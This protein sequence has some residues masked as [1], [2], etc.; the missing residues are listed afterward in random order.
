MFGNALATYV[1]NEVAGMRAPLLPSKSRSTFY[2]KLLGRLQSR[3]CDVYHAEFVSAFI[4]YRKW[5]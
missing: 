5:Y 4:D 2:Q 3:E 1:I